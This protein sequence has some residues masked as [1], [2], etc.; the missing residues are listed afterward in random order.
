MDRKFKH[1]V[2]SAPHNER[3]RKVYIL[4]PALILVALSP[5]S[6]YTCFLLLTFVASFAVYVY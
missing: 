6:K 1:T 2:L 3:L 5:F 4:A